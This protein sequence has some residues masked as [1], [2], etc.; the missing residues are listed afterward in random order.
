MHRPEGAPL[1]LAA[2]FPVGT[3]IDHG[4]NTEKGKGPETL[5]QAYQK[6]LATGAFETLESSNETILHATVGN[7]LYMAIL[8]KAEVSQ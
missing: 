5:E 7:R 6:V 1:Q 2:K 4:N 8:K 3:M